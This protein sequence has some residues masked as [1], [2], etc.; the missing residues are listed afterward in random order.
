MSDRVKLRAI[1]ARWF[2]RRRVRDHARLWDTRTTIHMYHD[3]DHQY[4]KLLQAGED[5]EKVITLAKQN[6]HYKGVK[7]IDGNMALDVGLQ[8]LGDLMIGSGTAWATPYIGVGDSSTAEAAAQTALQ[9]AT[10]KAYAAMDSTYPKRTGKTVSFKATFAAG[11]ASWVWQEIVVLTGN[12]T[13]IALNR[14]VGAWGTKGANDT[15]SMQVDITLAA[16]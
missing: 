4:A 15:Y 6:G 5:E 11:V 10:N 1:L 7:V 9:A 16:A 8:N 13:G 3:P 14:K 12:G 2:G